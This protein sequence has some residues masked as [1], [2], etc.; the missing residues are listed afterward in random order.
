MKTAINKG[1]KGLAMLVL[2]SSCKVYN[3]ENFKYTSE[4]TSGLQKP[5][6]TVIEEE[7]IAK[8]YV[9]NILFVS[10]YGGTLQ[11]NDRKDHVKETIYNIKAFSKNFE[12]AAGE[13]PHAFIR[14]TIDKYAETSSAM[15][16]MLQGFFL[17]VPMLLGAPLTT[18]KSEVHMIAGLYDNNKKLLHQ[19]EI[20]GRGKVRVGGYGAYKGKTAGR[21][22]NANAVN[23]ALNQLKDSLDKDATTIN[24]QLI[25]SKPIESTFLGRFEQAGDESIISTE[26]KSGSGFVISETGYVVTN[27]HVI[28]ASNKVELTFNGDS[29]TVTYAASVVANDQ[30]NDIAILK[31]DDSKFTGFDKIPYTVSDEYVVGEKVFTIGYPQPDLMGTDFKYTSGE[32]NSLTGI[33]NNVSM[34]Q[35][36]VPIQPGNSGGPLFNEKGDV[37]G[38]TTS[39]LNPFYT[40]KYGNSIPQNVNY[41]VKADYLKPIS[42]SYLDKSINTIADKSTKDKVAILNKFTCLVRIF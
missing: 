3:F 15:M 5:L 10:N 19:Y 12:P 26:I 21:V 28:S 22:S 30:A 11:T 38:I 2:V 34:M 33:E 24:E 23:D 17:F 42:K 9:S 14:I 25:A 1:A 40:A 41:A 36:S 37:I 31:I 16:P 18:G 27:F 6:R 7:E 32:I 39:T 20:T 4:G 35:I 8:A 13:K 29:G